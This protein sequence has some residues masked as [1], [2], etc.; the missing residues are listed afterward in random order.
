[1]QLL[2]LADQGPMH[3]DIAVTVRCFFCHE[4][5]E[6]EKNWVIVLFSYALQVSYNLQKKLIFFDKIHCQITI[7]QFAV[8]AGKEWDTTSSFDRH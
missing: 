1:M 2:R 6:H 3:A 7:L 5:T 4:S 8:A